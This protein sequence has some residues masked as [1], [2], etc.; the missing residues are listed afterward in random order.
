MYMDGSVPPTT[1]AD[2]YRTWLVLL[3]VQ[4]GIVDRAQA[5]RAGF[6]R[7]QIEYRVRSGTWRTVYPATYAT[8]NGPLS[9]DARLWA[10][11]LLAGADAMLSH[12]TA[13]EVHGIIDKPLGTVIHLTVPCRRRPAQHK[14][15][16]GIAIHRSDQ[17]QPQMVGPFIL[18]RTRRE[19]TVLDLVAAAPTFDHAYTWIT[20]AVSRKLVTVSGL[21]AALADRHRVRW[22]NWLM[23]ALEDAGDGVH[24]SLERRYVRDVERAHGLPRS[25]HQSR[26]QFGDKA[27]YR[28]NWYAAYRVVVEIDGPSYHQNEQVQQDKYRD[29]IN[30]ALDDVKTH[31]FGPVGVTERACQ[32]AALVAATLQRGG[33][34]GS[35]R[36]CR[37]PDCTIKRPQRT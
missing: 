10:A 25:L 1:D 26:R 2:T 36:P 28:D 17:S 22:R 16:P 35:P 31:R 30:L 6:T 15:V 32:T 5:L 8:F 33:W 23:E 19:D 12:E 9:R 7:R 4:Q 34:K 24:S 11:V 29:S 3:S 20:R 27:H 13:A 21:R 14:P 37:R 18:P